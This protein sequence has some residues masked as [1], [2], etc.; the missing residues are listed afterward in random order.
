M[1]QI[2][3][4]MPTG[5]KGNIEVEPDVPLFPPSSEKTL[6]ELIKEKEQ[7]SFLDYAQLPSNCETAKDVPDHHM[8]LIYT[9]PRRVEDAEQRA[10]RGIV[11][12]EE[13]EPRAAR[14]IVEEEE[15]EPRTRSYGEVRYI[16]SGFFSRPKYIHVDSKDTVRTLI[17]LIKLKE[18]LP[19]NLELIYQGDYEKT[20]EKLSDKPI[21]LKQSGAP[22]LA[23]QPEPEPQE[24]EPDPPPPPQV[25]T[26]R[27]P[28]FVDEVR[29]YALDPREWR[30]DL[31]EQRERREP[32]VL[33]PRE[34]REHARWLAAQPL[35]GRRY[36]RAWQPQRRFPSKPHNPRKVGGYTK[37][38]KRKKTKRHR[39]SKKSRRTRRQRR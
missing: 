39:K 5:V 13:E 35:D 9:R 29:Y 25:T 18:G 19:P 37:K 16:I 3:Y 15:E 20:V 1:V 12:E 14:G 21:F 36:S 30:E 11:E 34:W 23:T 6:I 8:R 26:D 27:R 38:Y 24:P 2:F 10:A 31:R 33:D 28:P 17:E 32:H 4:S 22:P 7:N